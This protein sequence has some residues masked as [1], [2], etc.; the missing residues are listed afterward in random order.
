[1]K[2][3]FTKLMLIFYKLI[4]IINTNLLSGES[5]VMDDV[6]EALLEIKN[7]KPSDKVKTLDELVNER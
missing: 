7:R 5:T 1:M 6:E 4:S 2:Y 3:I